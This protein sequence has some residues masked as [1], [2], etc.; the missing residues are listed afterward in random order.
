[1]SAALANG[2]ATVLSFVLGFLKI[3]ILASIIVSWVG[4]RNNQIVQFIYQLSE[5]IFSPLRKLTSFIP[6]PLDFAPLVAFVI[7]EL[8][9][10]TVVFALK[11]YAMN[12]GGF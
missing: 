10:S 12:A 4:D 5:P 9:N 1:M 2:L 3:L 8:L 11:R 7:I 6:G